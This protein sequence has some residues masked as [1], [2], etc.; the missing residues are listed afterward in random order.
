MML[1]WINLDWMPPSCSTTSQVDRVRKYGKKLM[2][3]DNEL[4][5][6]TYQ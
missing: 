2:N 1:W 4:K 5:E 6:I 3:Q